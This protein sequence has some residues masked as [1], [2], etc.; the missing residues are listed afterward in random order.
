[1]VNVLDRLFA[2]KPAERRDMPALIER[3][4]GANVF[5]GY[6]DAG[7]PYDNPDDLVKQKGVMTFR[8]MWRRDDMVRAAVAYRQLAGISTGWQMEPASDDPADQEPADYAQYALDEMEGSFH[9][10]LVSIQD[11]LVA[12]F[13]IHEKVNAPVETEGQWAGKQGIA[14]LKQRSP[15]YIYFDLD[16]HGEIKE[17][18]IW[19][20]ARIAHDQDIDGADYV[21]FSREEVIYHVTDPRDSNPFGNSP[22]RPAYRAYFNRDSTT[23]AW[24][25]YLERY[26]LPIPIGRYPDTGADETHRNTLMNVLKQMRTALVLVLKRSWDVQF[27][28]QKHEGQVALFE[29]MIAVA[30]RQIARSLLLPALVMET[31]DGGGGAYALGKAQ[32]DQFSWVLRADREALE[33]TINQQLIRPLIRWNFSGVGMPR[34]R[35]KPF[36]DEDLKQQAEWL[37]I[38]VN[39]GLAVPEDEIYK[40]FRLRKPEEGE[41]VLEK[42]ATGGNGGGGGFP[43]EIG[44]V[45]PEEQEEEEMV[46]MAATK[47]R[48]PIEQHIN[49]EATAAE[50]S[51]A[52][53]YWAETAGVTLA[54]IADTLEQ[55]AGKDN[56]GRLSK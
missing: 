37:A 45:E 23:I 36:A 32:N 55:E 5:E 39:Q 6:L 29:R 56:G 52:C 49:F 21:K 20:E 12:G 1:M 17:N 22:L 25:R 2:K 13:S 44:A 30:S 54:E 38:L 42:A 14:R 11:A 27:L 15:E 33:E 7:I 4:L 47:R 41:E 10:T 18:G 34:W 28:E 16:L 40:R 26:G 51:T 35:L 46:T 9:Q 19:Q 53:R 24:A 8:D 43:P 31:A 3:G 48:F 50:E